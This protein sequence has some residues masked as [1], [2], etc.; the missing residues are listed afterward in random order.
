MLEA[1]FNRT[2]PLRN[3]ATVVAD[4]D[5]L[6]ES[7]VNPSAKVVAGYEPIMPTFEGI[8]ST[9]DL[10]A[11]IAYIKSL[12]K[13]ETPSRVESFPPPV[14]VDNPDAKNLPAGVKPETAGANER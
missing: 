5:Y 6:R 7:I 1:I 11:L 8:V 13:G 10:I 3:G 4:E 12:E 2:I 14:R 9:E